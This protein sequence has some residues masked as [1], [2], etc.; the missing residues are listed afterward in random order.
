MKSLTGTMLGPY[1]ILE[2]I[3]GGGMAT[4]YKAYQPSVDR[5]VALKVVRVDI[6]EQPQF[7]ER[8][9]RFW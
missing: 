7:R 3:G 4:V 6:A 8:F 1:A 5:F 9:L 2:Q